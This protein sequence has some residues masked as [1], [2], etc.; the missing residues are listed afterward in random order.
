MK[1]SEDL[2]LFVLLLMVL[3]CS[4]VYSL[5][6]VGGY[7]ETPLRNKKTAALELFTL[8]STKIGPDKKGG[9]LQ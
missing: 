5:L 3:S 9:K 7:V 6:E 8:Q 2:E 1:V 4:V